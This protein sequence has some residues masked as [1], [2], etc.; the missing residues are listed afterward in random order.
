[1]TGTG[2]EEHPTA[3]STH[4][5]LELGTQMR[6]AEIQIRIELFLSGL[7]DFLREN[8][9]TLIGHI[10]GLLDAGNGGQLFFSVTSFNDGI[11]YKGGLAGEAEE[12]TLW[13]NVIVYGVAQEPIERAIHEQLRKQF[14]EH[15]EK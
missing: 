10:K 13:I 2:R 15:R 14:P 11:R 5:A 12:A 7:T 1:M 3:C 4:L 9:C 6:A 8:G